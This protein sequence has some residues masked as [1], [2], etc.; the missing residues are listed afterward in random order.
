MLFL[1]SVAFSEEERDAPD[2][3]ETYQ[4][5]DHAADGGCLTAKEICDEIE[6]EYTYKTPVDAADYGKHQSDS[7]HYHSC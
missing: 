4:S 7:V 3:G 6:S 1:Y 5:V 2:G